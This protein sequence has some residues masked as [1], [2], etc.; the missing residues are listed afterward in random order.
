MTT[1]RADDVGTLKG[2]TAPLHEALTLDRVIHEPA[3]LAILA[4]LSGAE[5]ADFAFL[6]VATG[7]SKGNLSKQTAKL[8]ESGYI[9]I[10]KYHRGRIPATG[11]RITPMGRSALAEYGARITALGQSVRQAGPV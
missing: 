3:R 2:A 6:L 11:Y 1:R 8:E 5:E 9:T 7:L 4:V 10:R